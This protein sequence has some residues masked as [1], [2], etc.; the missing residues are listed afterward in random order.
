M[1]RCLYGSY[2]IWP[3]YRLLPPLTMQGAMEVV[4]L[5]DHI[6]HTALLFSGPVLALLLLIEISLMLLGRFAPQIKLN[7]LSPTIK[8]AAFGIIMVSYTVFLMEY[9]GTEIIQS[10]GVLEWLGKFLK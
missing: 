5:L 10:Y 1:V 2:L 3:V 7:D 6:M 9:M 4:A 8:N